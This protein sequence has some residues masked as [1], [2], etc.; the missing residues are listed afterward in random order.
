MDVMDKLVIRE[1]F[2]LDKT[3]NRLKHYQRIKH[4]EF[5]QQSMTTRLEYTDLGLHS[6]GFRADQEVT[7]LYEKLGC[8]ERRII[9]NTFRSEHFKNCL[10]QLKASDLNLLESKFVGNCTVYIPDNLLRQLIVEI[11]EIETAICFREGLEIDPEEVTSSGDV[12]KDI[13][14]MTEVF[15][16]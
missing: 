16:I 14:N 15:A 9:R 11:Q 2:N 7:S 12:M 1:Y 4:W 13:T 10:G 5:Y 8:I 3:I 6:A